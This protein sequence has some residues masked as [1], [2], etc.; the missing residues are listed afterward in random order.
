MK[1]NDKNSKHLNRA[2]TSVFVG[3]LVAYLLMTWRNSY[4]SEMKTGTKIAPGGGDGY[5]AF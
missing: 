1:S 2:V 4:L 5:F 3:V